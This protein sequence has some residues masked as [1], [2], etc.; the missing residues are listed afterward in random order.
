LR[1]DV[2]RE[3]D[4]G[5]DRLSGDGRTVGRYQDALEHRWAIFER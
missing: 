3:R 5:L 4:P 2:L 1:V